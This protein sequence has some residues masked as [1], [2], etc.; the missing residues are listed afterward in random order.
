[1]T[2]VRSQRPEVRRQRTEDGRERHRAWGKRHKA[3]GIGQNCEVGR[4]NADGKA[5]GKGHKA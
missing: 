4:R 3:K 1:M 2:E 5:Q